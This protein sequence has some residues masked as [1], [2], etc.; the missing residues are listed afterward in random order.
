MIC[1]EVPIHQNFN[2]AFFHFIAKMMI[3]NGNVMS[4]WMHCQS[5]DE[6]NT[7]FINFKDFEVCNGC[8][9]LT[10]RN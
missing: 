5:F 4:S 6:L 3:L 7:H 1:L 10:T 8:I 2:L 9:G